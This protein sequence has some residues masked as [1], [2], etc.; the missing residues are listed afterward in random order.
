MSNLSPISNASEEYETIAEDS[1]DHDYEMLDKYNQEIQ[2][3]TP[4]E[5]V[6]Q[7]PQ[8]TPGGYELTQCPAYVPVATTGIYVNTS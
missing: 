6:Q 3:P 7:Q 5:P 2:A 4:P 1:T 8:S